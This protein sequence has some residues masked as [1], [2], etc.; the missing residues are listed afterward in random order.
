[1]N[2][3]S[4]VRIDKPVAGTPGNQMKPNDPRRM[5]YYVRAENEVIALKGMMHRFPGESLHIAH[6]VHGVAPF[7]SEEA[8]A[9]RKE[10]DKREVKRRRDARKHK[11]DGILVSELQAVM[12]DSCAPGVWA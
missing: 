9:E 12:Q 8:K 2:E 3:Y 4:I 10:M 7:F 11:H 1:M 5:R 6:T